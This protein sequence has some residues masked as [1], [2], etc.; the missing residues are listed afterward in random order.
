M[1]SE[2]PS[3]NHGVQIKRHSTGWNVSLVG[4]IKNSKSAKRKSWFSKKAWRFS[5][6]PTSRG[7]VSQDIQRSQHFPK[8]Y[9]E[10]KS[11][12]KKERKIKMCL[13]KSRLMSSHSI[14]SS[15]NILALVQKWQ[16]HTLCNQVPGS[17]LIRPA[18]ELV[19]LY[20]L[21]EMISTQETTQGSGEAMAW[22]LNKW[23][24]I[25]LSGENSQNAES[26]V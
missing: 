7:E 26:Q 17:Q 6:S 20:P 12:C 19:R 8:C 2:S 13:M 22:I 18:I 21:A 9:K 25:R 14:S 4:F 24:V 10:S 3:T 16:L 11:R 23:K 1:F 5:Y 15:K